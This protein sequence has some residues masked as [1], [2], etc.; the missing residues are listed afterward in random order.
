MVQRPNPMTGKVDP[1]KTVTTLVDP[2]R[3]TYEAFETAPDGKEFRSFWINYTR[4]K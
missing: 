2:D 3:Y 1:M 4:Q